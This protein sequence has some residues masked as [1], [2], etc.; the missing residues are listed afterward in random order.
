MGQPY[1]GEVSLEDGLRALKL[2]RN[3]ATTYPAHDKKLHARAVGN[4][5]LFGLAPHFNAMCSTTV[6]YEALRNFI[7]AA[8]LFLRGG[9]GRRRVLFL[10]PLSSACRSCTKPILRVQKI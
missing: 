6:N 3:L 9:R 2:L 1:S 7:Q 8:S 5:L 4:V 10:K